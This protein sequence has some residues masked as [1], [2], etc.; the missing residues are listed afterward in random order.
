MLGSTRAA[1][2]ASKVGVEPLSYH[3]MQ[4]WINIPIFKQTIGRYIYIYITISFD[5]SQGQTW[6]FHCFLKA[7][8][9]SAVAG[10]VVASEI[11]R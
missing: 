8:S 9:S 7:E 4:P 2:A 1:P 6:W 3:R 10:M 11:P 5:N